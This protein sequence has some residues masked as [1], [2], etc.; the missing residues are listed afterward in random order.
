[1]YTLKYRL[2][3]KVLCLSTELNTVV[4]RSQQFCRQEILLSREEGWGE[5]IMPS[6]F[7]IVLFPDLL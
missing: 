4:V 5:M 7:L 2:C 3:L 6:A 1:M